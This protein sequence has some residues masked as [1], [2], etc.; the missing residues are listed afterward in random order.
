VRETQSGWDLERCK[1]IEL[2]EQLACRAGS[3]DRAANKQQQ[4]KGQWSDHSGV[5]CSRGEG[6]CNALCE[7]DMTGMGSLRAPDIAPPFESGALNDLTHVD[8]SFG[9]RMC[10]DGVLNVGVDSAFNELE[11]FLH[12]AGA[13][14]G[15]GVALFGRDVWAGNQESGE[16]APLPYGYISGVQHADVNKPLRIAHEERIL[17]RVAL[18]KELQ[19]LQQ[20]LNFGSK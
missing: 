8:V 18:E 10:V 6:A 17:E 11:Q 4:L 16:C 20:Q 2:Q 9:E 5:K 12:H 3:D 7:V 15:A 1:R 19:E 14:G 13:P